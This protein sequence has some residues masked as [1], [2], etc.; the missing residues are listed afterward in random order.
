MTAEQFAYW[1]QGFAELTEGTQPTPEQ[2]KSI[3]DHLNTVFVKVTPKIGLPP[4]TGPVFAEP[5]RHLTP[6]ERFER[7]VWPHHT[8][9]QP[10][11]TC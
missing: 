3:N 9:G 2:W 4:S 5:A 7:S 11:I 1:L 8:I 10:L 6:L